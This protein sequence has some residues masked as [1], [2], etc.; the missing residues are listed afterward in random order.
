MKTVQAADRDSYRRMTSDELRGKFL[1][2]DLFQ[3]GQAEF[4]YTNVDRAVVGGIVPTDKPLEL[5]G[6]KEMACGFFCERREAGVINLGAAGT[7]R[8]DGTT[9]KVAP[10]E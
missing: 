2:A 5:E 6:G 4:F 9:Y 1:V 7:V 8:V 3:P 10:R